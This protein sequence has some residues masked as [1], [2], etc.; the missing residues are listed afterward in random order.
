MEFR[1]FKTLKEFKTK[2]IVLH[3]LAF[4]VFL[5]FP[6]LHAPLS[7]LHSQ[8][9]GCGVSVKA[10]DKGDFDQALALYADHR[11]G[12]ASRIMSRV[13]K[14][15]PKAA[16]PQFWLGMISVKNGFQTGG[17][18]RYF[19]KC[20]DLCPTYPHALAHFYMGVV[21]YTDEHY[22]EAVVELEKYF[23]LATGSDDKDV[24]GVYE[25]A[26]AY[27]HWSQF[28]AEAILHMAPFDPYPLTGV[29][30]K[31]NELLPFITHDG[32][33]CYY[34]REVPVKRN[35]TAFYTKTMEETHL[36]LCR[37]EWRDSAFTK[38]APMP[39]P[40][41]G[42][43]P[44]GG[45]S[46]TCDGKTLYFSRITDNRGYA[47]SDLYCARWK[48]GLKKWVEEPLNN[49]INGDHSW[50][51]QP[52]VT[53]DGQ[54]LYF[55]SDRKG[56]LGGIDIWR[57]HRL[58][59]GDWSRPE[60]LGP[61]VN[62]TGNEKFPFIHSDSHTLYF[63]SDGWQ[64][65]GGYDIYF[66]DLVE[67]GNAYPTNLG[68]PINTENDELSFSVVADGSKAYFPGRIKS[69]RSTD[70]LMFDLY[71]AARPE[72]M[73]CHHTTVASTAG[74]YD[75]VYML[76]ERNLNTVV[77]AS[78]GVLPYIAC[79]KSSAFA[80]LDE[81]IL[82]DSVTPLYVDMLSGSRLAPAGECVLDAWAE[83]FFNHP[84]IHAVIECP[85]QTDAKAIYDYL[86]K[87][88]LRAERLSYRGGT[89]VKHPQ[90]RVP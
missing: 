50:E 77:M 74:V 15:N 51:S 70:I 44:E 64:G 89:D 72:P 1:N 88:K 27:L 41:N 63:L 38:G 48:E 67:G 6:V 8:T 10:G 87:K 60:N 55:A 21:H 69:S 52:S 59:N 42:G 83:W 37:S 40:F 90:L 25:E 19:T 5:L 11:Y 31:R 4:L 18:R 28:L 46:L 35:R 20:I 45:V 66:I 53:P 68:L 71:P 14:R 17:I 81:V 36:V 75:T 49:N 30:T 12:E 22:E 23:T 26:S 16:E 85:K 62:T 2:G 84:R 82:Y 3:C 33:A 79:G 32:Q 39:S 73:H 9:W 54:W 61:S 57:C 58:K 78:E 34:L 47:N 56:G 80:K 29:N 7:I 43:L 86:L 13:S 76:S 24:V 65:F